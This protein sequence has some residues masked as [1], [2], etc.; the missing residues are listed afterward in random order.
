MFQSE[1]VNYLPSAAADD[2]LG[3][4]PILPMVFVAMAQGEIVALRPN[5]KA[6]VWEKD[7]IWHQNG[8]SR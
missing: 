5:V 6:V 2:R 3:L 7:L 1:F 8:L 4:M